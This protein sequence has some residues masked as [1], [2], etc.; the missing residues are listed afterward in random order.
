MSDPASRPDPDVEL[1][2]HDARYGAVRVQAWHGLH[3][4]LS[5]RGRW[6]GADAAPIVRGTVMLCESEEEASLVIEA[7]TELEGVTC[8]VDGLFADIRPD[9]ILE[10]PLTTGPEEGYR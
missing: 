4:K 10:P 1:V 8:E 9:E 5:G 3:P 7:W 6:A 2:T